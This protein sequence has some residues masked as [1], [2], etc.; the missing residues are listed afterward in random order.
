MNQRSIVVAAAAFSCL[1]VAPSARADGG[2]F[3]VGA[4]TGFTLPLGNISGDSGNGNGAA[5]FSDSDTGFIPFWLDAGYRINPNI[6]VGAY[7]QYG[8]GLVKGCTSGTT[9][10]GADLSLGL[11]GEYHLLPLE[12]FDPWFGLGVGYELLGFTASA[13]DGS[14]AHET[15]TDKG[16][17]FLLQG[18]LD[19]AVTQKLH[20]GPF[21]ALA[22]GKYNS[23]STSGTLS[24]GSGDIMTTSVHELVTI[25]VRGT[26][27]LF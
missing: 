19:F 6:Y 21:L 18:G 26:F 27:N 15:G 4:R 3:Q 5:A 23:G 24:T 20:L 1:A 22:V 25:G 16:F 12:S 2:S 11:T 9:C 17:Q 8:I 7:L 14:G 13:N 10:S